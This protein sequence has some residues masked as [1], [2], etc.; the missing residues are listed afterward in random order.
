MLP[1]GTEYG[2]VALR[3]PDWTWIAILLIGGVSA[4]MLPYPT[5][6]ERIAG[7]L[8]PGLCLFL[9]AMKYGGV[10]GGDIKLTAAMGFCFGLYSLA[11]ILFFALI[12]ACIYAKATK[13]KSVPL[14]V[15]LGIGFCIYFGAVFASSLLV[16]G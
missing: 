7:F 14:A 6:L 11:A 15:F 4:F 16:G 8:L 1:R 10:G 13:Q 3:R 12:P 9:L 2:Y 5:L